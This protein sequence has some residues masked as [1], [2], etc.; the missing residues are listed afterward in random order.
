M[1]F[2]ASAMWV[3]GGAAIGF[4]AAVA[5]VTSIFVYHMLGWGP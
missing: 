1:S 5:A 4:V 2:K 3:L